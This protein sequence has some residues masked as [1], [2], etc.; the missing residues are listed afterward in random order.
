MP[1]HH[2][3]SHLPAARAHLNIVHVVDS[4]EVGGLERV[5]T[6]LAK[7]QKAAGHRVSV[8][9]INSTTGLKAE[10]Q[11]AGI[12]VIEGHKK[13]SLDRQVL[14]ALRSWI[15]SQHIDV[16]HAHN[17]VPNYHAAF[18]T[19]GLRHRPVQVCT[20]HDM[21]MRLSNRKL[22]WLFKWS[23]TRTA[24]V[25]MVG[26][27]VYD[28]YLSLGLVRPERAHAVL[29][30]IPVDRFMASA[31]RR[32]AARSDLGLTEQDLVI[33]CVGRLVPLKNHQRMIDVMPALLAGHPD[34][35]LVIVGDG[36]RRQALTDQVKQLGLEGHV[37]MAG[38]RSNVSQLLPAF[39]IFA[40]PSQ[41]EGVSI[42]LLEACATGLAVVATRVGG[43]PEIVQ[44]ALTG[45]LIPPDD[46]AALQAA[47]SQ[48][49]DAP[50]KRQ[51]MGHQA[52]KWVREHAS[53]LALREAY[54]RC[55]A[56]ALS[57]R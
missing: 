15:R 13:T 42:A 4:L 45:L 24:E 23:L 26:K 5:T 30:G 41:T 20:C 29:N 1:A 12:E 16:V 43:N 44:D 34:L 10:L 25:A 53:D 22:R 6:D 31:E 27:Q 21:G 48:L 52:A 56:R 38:Q 32:T 35:K 57:R 55:Y 36:E 37:L 33:G 8:F 18:A 47:L 49:L 9:S 46:N 17:F 50:L 19:L 3:H 2:P 51:E 28:R 14:G 39:D 54:D 40:L 11:A 7:A